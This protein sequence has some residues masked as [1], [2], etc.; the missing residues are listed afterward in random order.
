MPLMAT[1]TRSGTADRRNSIANLGYEVLLQMLS[2]FGLHQGNSRQCNGCWLQCPGYWNLINCLRSW[3][4]GPGRLCC[5]FGSWCDGQ[6]GISSCCWCVLQSNWCCS[7]F[8]RCWFWCLWHIRCCGRSCLP[9]HSCQC[10]SVR[11]FRSS[12]GCCLNSCGPGSGCQQELNGCCGQFG[13]SDGQSIHGR[14]R[15]CESNR[16]GIHSC[17]CCG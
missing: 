1:I 9:C 4:Q 2:L 11:S 14:G 8:C 7:Y 15:W 17:W 3:R 12:N 16:H 13:C 10:S 6:Q 5:G